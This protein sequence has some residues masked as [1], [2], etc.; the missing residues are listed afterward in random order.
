MA[1]TTTV[2]IG[3][4]IAAGMVVALLPAQESSR[5]R[6]SVYGGAVEEAS[7]PAPAPEPGLI[8][9]EHAAPVAPPAAPPL[10]QAPISD[11][12]VAPAGILGRR[13]NGS[14]GSL[15]SQLQASGEAASQEYT[16]PALQPAEPATQPPGPLPRPG[17]SIYQPAE[18]S[19][20]AGAIPMPTPPAARGGEEPI[21]AAESAGEAGQMRSVLKKMKALPQEEAAADSGPP[22]RVPV[23][24]PVAARAGNSSRRTASLPASPAGSSRSVAPALPAIDTSGITGSS[25]SARSPSLRVDVA[26]PSGISVGKPAAYLVTL[27]NESET[28]AQ[29]VQLR[30]S[31]P[32]FVTVTATQPTEGEAAM[33]ADAT[34]QPRLLWSLPALAAREH[35]T[36]R[37]SLVASEGQPFELGVEW[38]CRPALAKATIL[39]RQPQLQLSLAG[40]ADMTFGEEK[41]F[42]LAVS[43]PGNGDAENVVVQLAAGQN[44][45][46]QI[47]VGT[48]SAGQRKELPVQ[49]VASEAG[50]ME[51]HAV[52]TGEGDLSAEAIGKVIVRKA[53]LAVIVEGPQ[54]KFAGTDAAYAVVVQNTGNAAAD[55]VQIS[56]LLPAGAKY[57]GGVDGAAP[58]G[59]SLKWK[60][61]SLPAGSEKSFEV[62]L[63]LNAAGENTIG[64][65]AQDATG[66]SASGEAI[67]TVEAAA[68]LKLV[69]SDPTGPLA[70]SEVAEYQVQVMNR[71]SD[72]ARNVKIVM[73]FGEGIEPAAFEGC[74]AK[75][76]PGQVLCQPLTELAAGEQVTIRVK[77]RADRGGTH[78]F[79]VE[80]T[81]EDGARLVSEGTTR[82]FADSGRGEAA[83]TTAGKKPT[84]LPR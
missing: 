78:Q 64:V 50:E 15:S 77:A 23:N 45:R 43:N 1:R 5:R 16:P 20:P 53:E 83:T 68:D 35:Q 76:V 71:G 59:A 29:D 36:L 27:V 33:Q 57:L 67:T 55:N 13:R 80:V 46:Q 66:V 30:L 22:P 70:T 31:L 40:P 60:L 72:S 24:P 7:D 38:T 42:T 4:L 62:R 73:Q 54:L 75:I 41:T 74:E 21:P 32:G 69:V 9:V 34:G 51:I 6:P 19:P 37:L 8:P 84:L 17:T 28:A 18:V 12:S 44:R 52:A 11:G 61:A 63:Q 56:A 47:D 65:Q 2:V 39:V 3:L 81:S 49:L 14:G 79:R 25:I 48:V 82:F 26:G 58:A 10:A